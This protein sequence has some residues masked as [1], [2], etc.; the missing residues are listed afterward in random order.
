MH[1]SFDLSG[2]GQSDNDF[3]IDLAHEV[4]GH[5]NIFVTIVK[6]LDI[7]ILIDLSAKG[8]FKIC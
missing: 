8:E 7:C 3:R 4:K 1:I 6:T 5:I 2:S